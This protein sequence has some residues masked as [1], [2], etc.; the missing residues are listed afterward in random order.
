MKALHIKTPLIESAV[1]S[2]EAGR[3]VLLKMESAQSPGSFKIRGIGLA[4]QTYAK[5]G[6]SRFISSSGGNAGIAVAYAG[7]K[8]SIPVVVVVPETTTEKAKSVIQNLNA[9][10]IV[11]GA[12]FQEANALAQSMVTESD[13]FLHP[14]D[15]P[16]VWEGHSSLV[17]EVVTSGSKPDAII[18]SVGGGGLMSGV[19]EGLHRNGWSDVPV[20]TV[21]T[22]GAESLAKSV[23]AG[24][25]ITLDSIK[26]IATSLGATRVC[27]QAFEW[28]RRHPVHNIVTTDQAAVSA[29]L[30]FRDD[31]Q[32]I[33]EPACGAALAV[34][35]DNAPELESFQSI[36]I[37]VCGGVTASEEQLRWWA[38][39][40]A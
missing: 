12:S 35:Y 38:D 3:T 11:H 16:L 33:V 26:S 27:D 29:C 13:A 21:E 39:E 15:D 9:E 19:I 10:V 40:L 37:V 7:N 34:A 8:L 25:L 2:A 32:V 14:F 24:H 6:A 36:L 31:H 1:L 5:R 18:L 23:R 4:C 30:R 17:D 28:T 22:E 20:V